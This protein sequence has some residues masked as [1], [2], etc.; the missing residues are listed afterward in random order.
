MTEWIGVPDNYLDYQGFIY[1]ITNLKTG[2]YYIGKK[3]FHSKRI[4]KPLK[5]RKNKRHKTV[6][7]D[8]KNYWGSCNDL[9][10]DLEKL[11]KNFFR[12]E[13]IKCC[14]TKFDCAYQEL[15]LQIKYNVL[16]DPLSYNG[17]IN[18]RLRKRIIKR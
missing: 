3:F 13:I 12:R 9:K 18:V 2:Q 8:W 6:E 15:L 10:C 7:S 17:I 11:G 16:F 5:G 1:M 14:D 4:L